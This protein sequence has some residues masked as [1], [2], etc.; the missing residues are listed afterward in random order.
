MWRSIDTLDSD[1][2]VMRLE[3]LAFLDVYCRGKTLQDAREWY[4]EA[5]L[6]EVPPG[7]LGLNKA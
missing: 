6:T 3:I 1:E 4:A 5:F 7:G 2:S